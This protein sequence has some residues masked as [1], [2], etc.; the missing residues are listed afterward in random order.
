MP[1]TLHRFWPLMKFSVDHHFIYITARADEH[2]QQLQSYY[3]LAKEDLEEITKDWSVDL[4]ILED[5]TNISDLDSPEIAPDTP[6]PN[7]INKTEE[8]HDL[9]NTSMKTTS[10]LTEQGGNGGE[11][12]GIVFEQNKGG[13]TPPR[14][15]EDPLKKRKVFLSK[16]SS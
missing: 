16:P 15:E 8:V 12:D 11:I 10:I 14:D 3:K 7:K 1:N 6:R 9:D 5:P 13:V 4:L 2:K